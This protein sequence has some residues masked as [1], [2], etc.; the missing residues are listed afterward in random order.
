MLRHYD[1]LSYINGTAYDNRYRIIFIDVFPR[2][3][4]PRRLEKMMSRITKK[5]PEG[6]SPAQSRKHHI[7]CVDDEIDGTRI[8]GEILGEQG[9]SVVL[10]HCPL[11]ALRCDF[12]L[13][14]LAIVD[15]QMPELNGRELLLRMR[16]LGARFPVVL[17]SGAVDDLSH[18]DRV[19]F[20][21]CI[22][23]GRSIQ[24]LLDTITEFLDPSQILTSRRDR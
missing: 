24:H 20:A 22:E 10:Y 13:F 21:R 12:S 16:A 7:L 4:D 17:L 11:A 5:A 14:D 18:E 9:Y 1:T 15:F 2:C 3:R 6:A 19:L 8:R 23:K